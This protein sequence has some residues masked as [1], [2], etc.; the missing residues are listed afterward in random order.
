MERPFDN[1]LNGVL[2]SY[3][4]RR[5]PARAGSSETTSRGSTFRGRGL[6][7]VLDGKRTLSYHA[8]SFE[9]AIRRSRTLLP[10]WQ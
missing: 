10:G 4:V 6:R 2:N 8:S 9:P 1:T 7:G 5:W 3:P